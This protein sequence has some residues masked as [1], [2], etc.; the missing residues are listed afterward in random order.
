MTLPRLFFS[1]MIPTII[2]SSSWCG[3][4]VF[5]NTGGFSIVV[6]NILYFK[7][8]MVEG[9]SIDLNFTSPA[10][11]TCFSKMSSPKSRRFNFICPGGNYC[12][13]MSSNKNDIYISRFYV[14]TGFKDSVLFAE[15]NY[16][17]DV[18]FLKFFIL[19]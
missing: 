7:L 2:T 10:A 15:I 4:K 8:M 5:Y 13:F 19:G 18:I 1:L 16:L 14:G 6:F 3:L 11:Y 17:W 12:I 9:D